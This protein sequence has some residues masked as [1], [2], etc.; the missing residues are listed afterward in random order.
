MDPLVTDPSEQFVDLQFALQGYSLP[1][2]YVDDLWMEVRSILPWLETD[3]RA[4]MH[5]LTGLSPGERVWYLSR[6]T[7]LTLRLARKRVEAASGAL[8]GVQ[9]HVGEN[10]I[11]VG[12]ASV[13]EF[14]H[15]SV[16]YAKFVTMTPPGPE[17]AAMSEAEF[18]Q[19]CQQ[20]LV[21][22]GMRPRLVCGKP[23][24]AKTAN[25]VLSGFS[26]MLQGLDAE[27]TSKILETGLGGERK[28]GCG[29]FIPHK[30][31]TAVNT[32]E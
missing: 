24:R 30:S 25:G 3:Q 28:R 17:H 5:L 16:L 29:I 20:Q 1:D 32:M 19:A 12:A 31:G 6:R 14:T 7:R 27:S 9:L 10:T 13:R 23:Q 4:G 8:V 15:V 11:K 18:Q 21:D 22:M 2:D 26:L